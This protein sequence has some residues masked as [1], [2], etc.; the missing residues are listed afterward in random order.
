MRN[1]QIVFAKFLENEI[2]L[3]QG[4]LLFSLL[5]AF[6][7]AGY[8]IKL[9]NN[10]R[11]QE[12]EKY[13]QMAFSLENVSVV[14]AIPDDLTGWIYLFDKEDETIGNHAW[15]KKVRI[16]F[17]VFS[18]YWFEQPIIMPFTVHPVHATRNYEL[19]LEEYRATKKSIRVFFSGDTEGYVRNRV[20]YPKAKLPRLKIM[21]AI[22]DRMSNVSLFVEDLPVLSELSN[23]YANKCVIVDTGKIW[24]D[25]RYWLSNLAMADFFLSPP[26]YVMPMCH[27]AV[28]AMAVGAIPITNYPEWF[29]PALSDMENCIV[30]DDERDLEQKIKLALA[31]DQEQIAEMR[32]HAIKYYETYLKPGAFIQRIES[33]END[34]VTLLMLTEGNMAK[35]ASKLRKTSILMRGT[36]A[37]DSVVGWKWFLSG[38]LGRS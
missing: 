31:M 15:R 19:G 25:D 13:A 12:L 34:Q 3:E 26:G 30:F 37:A 28:E 8:Q 20:K 6:S 23:T 5:N 1:K 16:G 32:S 22:R 33:S 4:R 10:F 11:D 2:L 7:L 38:L 24:V 14:D 17:D 29:D 21:E 35:K 27:N 18:P 9:F 36:A